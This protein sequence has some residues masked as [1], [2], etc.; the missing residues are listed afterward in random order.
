MTAGEPA[1]RLGEV[2]WLPFAAATSLRVRLRDRRV[3]LPPPGHH[4]L[5]RTEAEA[6]IG[7]VG[8]EDGRAS[9]WARHGP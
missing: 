5:G 7:A 1:G 2:S 9:R 6:G 4:R 3:R 8:G